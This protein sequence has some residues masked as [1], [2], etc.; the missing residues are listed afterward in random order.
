MNALFEQEHGELMAWLKVVPGVSA[1]DAN[2]IL[3]S[4]RRGSGASVTDC[5]PIDSYPH[6]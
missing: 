5:C 2:Y 3:A 6:I 1:S 4:K